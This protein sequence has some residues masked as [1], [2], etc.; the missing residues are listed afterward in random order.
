MTSS[1]AKIAKPF[2]E[3]WLQ[4]LTLA[5]ASPTAR[6]VKPLISDIDAVS[7][8]QELELQL[9]AGQRIWTYADENQLL[10]LLMLLPTQ[11]SDWSFSSDDVFA[12]QASPDTNITT[13]QRW[14][15]HLGLSAGAF[16]LTATVTAGDWAELLRREAVRQRR[17]SSAA[18]MQTSTTLERIVTAK[19][20][21]SKWLMVFA[22]ADWVDVQYDE[23]F[24]SSRPTAQAI[25]ELLIAALVD[26]ESK[27]LPKALSNVSHSSTD[28][29]KDAVPRL[30]DLHDNVVS[31]RSS[32]HP[33]M[34]RVWCAVWP[35][36]Y[37]E[38]NQLHGK[39]DLDWVR[40]ELADCFQYVPKATLWTLVAA[41]LICASQ[42]SR[43]LGIN[44]NFR[45]G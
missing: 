15:E 28:P 24:E 20:D 41:K 14:F 3:N 2:V 29:W 23:P 4:A 21:G 35:V 44:G 27:V 45:R 34:Q 9:A 13:M 30:S 19:W 40:K 6:Q 1:T 10:P 11:Q 37:R 7:Q 17:M 26:A 42:L 33:W 31:K 16:E 39:C 36:I 8:T 22:D 18:A 43:G 25:E 32:L 38:Q 5:V 12:Y